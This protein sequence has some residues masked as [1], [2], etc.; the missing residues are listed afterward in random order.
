MNTTATTAPTVELTDLQRL[1][2]ELLAYNKPL[3]AKV[4]KRTLNS[5]VKK[6]W[7]TVDE[8]ELYWVTAAGREAVGVTEAQAEKP[9]REK[10]SRARRCVDCDVLLTSKTRTGESEDTCSYC[11]AAAG[12]DNDHA[13]GHAEKGDHKAGC[14]ECDT[15]DACTYWDEYTPV[16]KR[17]QPK[18]CYCGCEGT[19]GG[20]NYLP[21]HD[22]RHAGHLARRVVE[23]R[24][25]LETALNQLPWDADKLAAKVRKSVEL[26][27]A[28]AA[29]KAAKKAK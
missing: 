12:F 24:E 19:T 28:K 7:A 4:T 25:D 3:P 1:A 11:W 23:G 14:R 2:L 8:A 16:K 27:L 18:T 22:A 6:G 20:G 15:Y 9:K 17:K 29:A 21:G 13:D 5:L 10:A 26:G